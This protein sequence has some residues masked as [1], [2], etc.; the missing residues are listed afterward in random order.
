VIVKVKCA[1]CGKEIEVETTDL[2]TESL[3]DE[4]LEKFDTVNWEPT[5]DG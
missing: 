5:Q 2:Y 3:C 1:S 4:C